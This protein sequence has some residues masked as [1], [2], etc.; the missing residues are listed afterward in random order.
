[1]M[2]SSLAQKLASISPLV[3][4]LLYAEDLFIIVKGDPEQ[5]VYVFFA[6]LGGS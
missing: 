3:Q 1:M 5:A 6:V 4:V 2:I